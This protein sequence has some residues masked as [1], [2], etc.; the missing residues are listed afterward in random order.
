MTASDIGFILLAAAAS[1]SM[2]FVVRAR[3]RS[4]GRYLVE[5]AESEI[6]EHLRPALMRLLERN[7]TV[8]RVGQVGPDMPLEIHLSPP[9]DPAAIQAELELEPPVLLSDRGVLYC[10]EDWCELHQR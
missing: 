3:R 5:L 1:I 6:C 2:V 4:H 7:H 8:T 10:K 9:F